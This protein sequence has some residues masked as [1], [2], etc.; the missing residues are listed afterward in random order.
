MNMDN[1]SLAAIVLCIV[2]YLGYSSYLS[3]KYPKPIPT[4]TQGPTPSASS[5]TS[6]PASD[7]PAAAAQASAPS[8]SRLTADDLKLESDVAVYQFSQDMAGLQ[9][10]KLKAFKQDATHDSAPVELL[11]S[12]MPVQ[13]TAD[14]KGAKS[15]SGL[16]HAERSGE[17]LKF[18]RDAGDFRIAQEWRVPKEG[19]GAELKVTF[20]NIAGKPIELTGGLLVQEQIEEKKSPSLLGIIPGTVRQRDT[21]IYDADGTTDWLDIEKFCKDDKDPPKLA[22]V[23]VKYIGFD[24][25]YFLTAFM[26]KAKSGSVHI[27]HD[28]MAG[29]A[30]PLTLVNFDKQGLIQPGESVVL[31]FNTYFGPK[32]LP[33]LRAHDPEL[34]GAMHL[35]TFGFIGRPLL[36]VIQ[37]FFRLTHNYGLAIIFVTLCLKALFYPLVRASSRSMHKMKQLN[38]QMSAIREKWKSDPQRQQQELM[39]F[40]GQNKINPAKGCLPILPQIPVFFAFYQVLQTSIALRHAPFFGWIQDLS[41]MDPYFVTPLL[42]GAAMFAQQRLT[43]TTGMDKTQEKIL[44][45]MPIMF[46]AMM[47]TLPAGLTLYMLTNTVTGIAQQKWLYLKL[48]KTGS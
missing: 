2:F 20:T 22:N 25:H 19:Y 46:T 9:S 26:P 24:R 35:G 29:H 12:P 5:V 13:G 42:M 44:M 27:D 32:D 36:S 10:V 16:F 48:D 3:H 37:G 14:V 33:I 6:A 41:A 17:S 7:V 21:I 23:P 8:P 43:P 28:K 1:R 45:F 31:D 4:T 47:L 38:P 40:M 15:F 11:D 39:K 30:C 34:E 18:W